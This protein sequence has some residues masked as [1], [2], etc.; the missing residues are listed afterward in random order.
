MRIHVH[1]VC[2]HRNG[3]GG[4]GFH[5]VLFSFRSGGQTHRMVACVFEERGNVAVLDIAETALGNI[6]FA[7][8]NSW[9]GDEFE[10]QLRDAIERECNQPICAECRKPIGRRRSVTAKDGAVF[11]SKCWNNG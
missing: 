7:E 2:R 8:G 3:V 6:G 11:H 9:R 5:V 1:K 4:N 10:S